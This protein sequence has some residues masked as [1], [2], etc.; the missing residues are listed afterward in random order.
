[1]AIGASVEEGLSAIRGHLATLRDDG[2]VSLRRTGGR[3]AYSL[4]DRGR[5]VLELVRWLVYVQPAPQETS[6]AIPID[7]ELLADVG[8]FVHDP[9]A[10]FR[11]PNVV[12]EGRRPVELLGTPDEQELRDR[13]EAAKLGMFS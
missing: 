7:P 13:I 2:L 9:A 8:G 6:A 11:T 5:R 12:F 10:W 1:M 4:T 3:D